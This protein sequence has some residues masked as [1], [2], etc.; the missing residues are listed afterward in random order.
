MD[1]KD[2]LY[3]SFDEQEEQP[4]EKEVK[5][6]EGSNRTFLIGA[7]VLAAVFVLGICAVVAYLFFGRQLT[8]GTA[9]Q[10]SP[11]EL[12]NN[13]A[14][15]ALA[16]TQT[17]SFLTQSAPTTAP[18]NTATQVKA[19]ATPTS[20][21][22]LTT[23]VGGTQIAEVT[24]VTG[25]PGTLAPGT[26]GTAG[27]P[28]TPGTPKTTGTAGPTPTKG[29]GGAQPTSTATK[30]GTPGTPAA[31]AGG[32]GGTVTP[33][34][35]PTS[36]IIEVTPLGGGAT[37][38]R[39]VSGV[40]GGAASA[41]PTSSIVEVTGAP[42]GGGGVATGQGGPFTVTASATLPQGGFGGGVGLAGAGLL[43][44]LLVIVV[45]VVR[46]IRLQP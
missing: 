21:I 20:S 30:A 31:P 2:G 4:A 36:S 13:A 5:A 37:P 41:T 7:I 16:F 19:S 15:T 23:P 25:T 29:L 26:T 8:G 1:D 45:I 38:T 42:G 6:E 40:A 32:A 10:V 18:T 14:M 12:T 27:T 22:S 3:F 28:G 9:Q 34:L 24:S 44:V 33:T 43:A 11:N 46:K 35:K 17:A 39:I